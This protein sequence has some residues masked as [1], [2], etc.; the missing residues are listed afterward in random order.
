MTDNNDIVIIND[1]DDYEDIFS[2]VGDYDEDSVAQY[3]SYYDDLNCEFDCV[4]QFC[5][6]ERLELSTKFRE[7]FH[8][9]WRK[10]LLWPSPFSLLEAP[11]NITHDTVLEAFSE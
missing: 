1:V 11:T 4:T 3:E 9:I 7:W 10:P 2:D 5:D 8:N 6:D